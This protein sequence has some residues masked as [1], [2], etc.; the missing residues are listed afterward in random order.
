MNNDIVQMHSTLA[1]EPKVTAASPDTPKQEAAPDPFDPTKLRLSQ[2]FAASLGV[3]KAMLTLPVRKPSKEW[4]VRTHPT[5]E[6]QL[7]TAVI[8]L[9]EDRETY[10]VSPSLRPQLVGE[11]TFGLRAFFLATNRQKVLF[12]WPVKLPGSDGKIDEW[13]RS[14]LDAAVLASKQW[15]RVS[16]NMGL[17]AYEVNYSTVDWGEPEWPDLSMGQ[18]LKIAFKDRYIDNWDHAVLKRLRGEA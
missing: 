13:S 14:A 16:A 2:D 10:L 15:G 9:K 4:W 1:N 12:F 5:E 3:K 18:L 7:Q 6:Y 17:G 8:E 11:P